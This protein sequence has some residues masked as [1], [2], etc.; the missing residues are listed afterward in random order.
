MTEESNNPNK[1]EIGIGTT[2]IKKA[3]DRQ[4]I[5]QL[6]FDLTE[7]RTVDR[8]SD[9]SLDRDNEKHQLLNGTEFSLRQVK[10]FIQSKARPYSPMYRL[11]F[12]REVF[13]IFDWPE[14]EP[15]VYHKRREAAIFIK[16]V[17]YGRFDKGVLLSFH[18]LNPYTG[19]IKRN[20][21]HFQFLT[22]DGIAQLAI[23]IDQAIKMM[24]ECDTYYE[25]RERWFQTF[26]VPYQ[27]DI[28]KTI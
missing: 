12:W 28:F 13:R 26:G 17:I 25:F 10:S 23:I 5:K 20:Y 14:S 3:E 2:K 22:D 15:S 4:K 11:V 8:F 6:I 19:F 21:K 1:T 16:E 7:Q 9:K 18:V 27:I 24:G